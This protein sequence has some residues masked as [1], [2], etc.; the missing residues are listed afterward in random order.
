VS[1]EHNNAHGL[2]ALTSNVSRGKNSAFGDQA[3]LDS[4]GCFNTAVGADALLLTTGDS[5]VA[6]GENAGNG[7]TTTNNNI[8]I[9]HSSGVHS[10]FGQVSDRCFIDNIYGAPVSAAT[11]TAVLVDSDGR[12]GTVA[13]NGPDRGGFSPLPA[14]AY[15]PQE[16][17]CPCGPPPRFKENIK[18]MDKASESILGLKPI[19]FRYKKE[20]DAKGMPQFGLLAEEVAKVNPDLVIFDKEATAQRFRGGHRTPANAN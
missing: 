11:A 15:D 8:I 17:C 5:N 14:Q 16:G 2:M 18:P 1:G 12:L 10:V 20:F 9:G 13:M 6:L 3:L 4:T 19:T 7:L